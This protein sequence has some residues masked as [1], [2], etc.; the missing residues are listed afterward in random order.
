[1]NQP[2]KIKI[3]SF[4][5]SPTAPFSPPPAVCL[6]TKFCFP[7]DELQLNRGYNHSKIFNLKL[8]LSN[9]LTISYQCKLSWFAILT[10]VPL[11][12]ELSQ[13]AHHTSSTRMCKN[14]WPASFFPGRH[15]AR[16]VLGGSQKFFECFTL[17]FPWDSVISTAFL[18]MH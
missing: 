7:P 8:V 3:C 12:K 14:T 2:H 4:V 17:H 15:L 1:M 5:L 10:K 11:Y 9:I 18:F 6:S 13:H 16:R